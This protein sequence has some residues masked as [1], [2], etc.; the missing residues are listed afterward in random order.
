MG[1]PVKS[2]SGHVFGRLLVVEHAASNMRRQPLWKCVCECGSE[3]IA[4]G[5]SLKAGTTSSCGCY[6]ADVRRARPKRDQKSRFWGMV[7]IPSDPDNC[8]EWQGALRNGYGVFGLGER[9]LGIEY[10]HRWSYM[11]RYEFIEDGLEVCHH[12][13]NRRCVNPDHLY[14]GTRSDNVTDRWKRTGL[15]LGDKPAKE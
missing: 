5:S 14:A 7:K 8:W 6:R 11:Q 13:D 4:L 3:T 1:R 15:R 12:C 9:K 2:L 10:A